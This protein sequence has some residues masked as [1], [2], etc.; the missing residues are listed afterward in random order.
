MATKQITRDEISKLAERLMARGSSSLMRGQPEQQIDLRIAAQVL[1][2]MV[3]S[4]MPVTS[5]EIDDLK[6]S[7]RG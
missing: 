6:N 3:E 2:Y 1:S 5:I 4:G 7:L